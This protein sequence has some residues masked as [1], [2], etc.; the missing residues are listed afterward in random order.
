MSAI[1]NKNIPNKIANFKFT[2]HYRCLTKVV[3][4]IASDRAGGLS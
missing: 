1:N 2:R 3:L 4:S